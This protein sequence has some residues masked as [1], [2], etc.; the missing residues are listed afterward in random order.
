MSAVLDASACLTYLQR[1]AGAEVVAEVLTPGAYISVV[2]AEVL[3]KLAEWG[4][5]P[6]EAYLEMMNRG[7]LGGMLEVTR[8]LPEECAAIARLRP[9]SKA[10]A[11]PWAT[12]R[13]SPWESDSDFRCS[14]PTGN[15]VSLR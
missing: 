5:H 13:V 6:E 9:M 14:P 1:E 11:F 8:L 4:H 7:L 2:L 3:S 10:W 15:G 12:A